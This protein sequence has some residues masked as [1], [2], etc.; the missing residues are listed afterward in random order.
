M[1]HDRKLN[2]GFRS[3]FTNIQDH[4]TY[5]SFYCIKVNTII[6]FHLL[7]DYKRFSK[8]FHILL[9]RPVTEN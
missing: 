1:L 3:K 6:L 4:K 8:G 5:A 9:R 7:A 2:K